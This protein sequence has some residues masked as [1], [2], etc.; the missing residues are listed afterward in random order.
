[1]SL[2]QLGMR[3]LPGFTVR[4]VTGGFAPDPRGIRQDQIIGTGRADGVSGVG[5]PPAEGNEG[6]G[7]EMTAAEIQEQQDYFDSTAF[8]GAYSPDKDYPDTLAGYLEK[9]LD[10]A[11]A[12]HVEFNSLTQSY[13]ATSP[14]GIIETAMGPLAGFLA[15]GA[16]LSKANLENINEQALAGTPGYAVGLFDN[17]ILGVS[18]NAIST[19]LFGMSPTEAGVLSGTI[20]DAPPGFTQQ[21]FHSAIMDAL[22]GAVPQRSSFPPGIGPPTAI[23]DV[24]AAVN[25]AMYGDV[26]GADQGSNFTGVVTSYDQNTGFKSAVSNVT[27]VDIGGIP[28]TYNTPVVNSPPPGFIMGL[29][30]PSIG[31]QPGGGNFGYG[32]DPQSDPGLDSGVTGTGDTPAGFDAGA[33]STGGVPDSAYGPDPGAQPNDDDAGHTGG[34]AA[35]GSEADTG[36]GYGGLGHAVGGRVGMQSGGTAVTEG[37]VNKDPRTISDKQGIADNRFTSVPQGSFV[38]NQPANEMYKDDLDVVLND[39]EK[40]A[41]PAQNDGNMVDVA[42]SDGERLIR[43]EVVDFVEKKYGSS[44]LD[45]INNTGKPEVQRRQVKYGEKIGAANGGLQADRGFLQQL[46]GPDSP[47]LTGP[48]PDKSSPMNLDPV[49]PSDDQFFGRRFGDIK[50]AIQN[51]EIKGFEKDPYIFTGIKRKG[52]ASSAFGPMQI[53]ASTL[54]DI[55]TRSPM[56]NTLD[57]GG[58]EYVDLLIQQGDDKVNIEKYGSMYRNKKRV[59]TPA[60]IKKSYRKY[61]KGT[62][63]QDLH[64]KYYD[65]IANI[66]LRQKLKDH[67]S[68][69]K[70]LASY[71]EGDSYASKVLSGLD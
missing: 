46:V 16:A 65:E 57:D 69:E 67:K 41:G 37:F 61:G 44:F 58:K 35:D 4:A 18:P 21:E 63:P 66:T 71:G 59:N 19:G 5:G 38:M 39:A 3:L 31:G 25:M 15:A 40:Q 22:R 27:S 51:V 70:A 1:M 53:T 34:G 32:P 29:P 55:K 47:T 13:R 23:P 36:G 28:V 56:Y 10:Y 33:V 7:G 12:P 30:S 8:A 11:L 2:S 48:A 64:E 24:T 42:L 6:D 68:L 43:P 45:N 17:A 14:G 49:S 52:K 62:I 9:A 20:P 60:K 50:A 54:K 26:T